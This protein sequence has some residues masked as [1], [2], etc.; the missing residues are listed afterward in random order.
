MFDLKSFLISIKLVSAFP[1][2]IKKCLNFSYRYLQPK[3]NNL[4]KHF[5]IWDSSHLVN[6]LCSFA[7]YLLTYPL[8]APP[9]PD[10]CRHWNRTLDFGA[11]SQLLRQCLGQ[12]VDADTCE[13]EEAI[14]N[15]PVT[16]SQ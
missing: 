3:Y 15:S 8:V 5:I 13:K 9:L 7:S 16:N 6:R 10:A 11:S 2:I 14:E 1:L 4:K 12:R